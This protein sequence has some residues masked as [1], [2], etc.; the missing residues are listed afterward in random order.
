MAGFQK[1]FPLLTKR[2]SVT[3]FRLTAEQNG[4][5][6]ADYK[7][8]FYFQST[9]EF[10]SDPVVTVAANSSETIW[11]ISAT[12]SYI[13][14][15]FN[16]V[17]AL[18]YALGSLYPNPCRGVLNI[19]YVIPF[20]TYDQICFEIFDELGRLVWKKDLEAQHSGMNRFVW[21]GKGR[22]GQDLSAGFYLMRFTSRS[23]SGKITSQ[24][25]SK[26]TYL[27]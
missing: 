18:K 19:P 2:D 25:H 16:K 10:S 3:T 8:V 17:M 23:G 13:E 11:V 27:P 1:R 12:N 22:T 6:P 26:F 20:G 9:N 4:N 15:Y 14:N 5:F 24:F 21:D 7:T